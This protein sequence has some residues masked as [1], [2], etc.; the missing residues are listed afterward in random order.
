MLQST[1][2]PL[3]REEAALLGQTARITNSISIVVCFVMIVVFWAIRHFIPTISNRVILRLTFYVGI[4]DMGYAIFQIVQNNFISPSPLCTTSAWAIVFFNLLS[5]FLKVLV[6][7]HLQ[8]VF[9]NHITQ[10]RKYEWGYMLAAVAVATL[11]S[12]S[13]FV[14]G[15]Y[16]WEPSQWFCWFRFD[17]SPASLLWQ[18]LAYY[19]WLTL[20]VIYCLVIVLLVWRHIAKVESEIQNVIH[21]PG[22][23]D[24]DPPLTLSP[25]LNDLEAYRITGSP[26]LSH[27]TVLDHPL[28][29]PATFPTATDYRGPTDEPVTSLNPSFLG[30]GGGGRN[31]SEGNLAE[32]SETLA[33]L[34]LRRVIW[35]P[36]IPVITQTAIIANAFCNYSNHTINIPLYI[37]A[38]ALAGLQGFL[39]G[40]VFAFDP[41]V[42]RAYSRLITHLRERY[43]FQY[44]LLQCQDPKS[45]STLDL[46]CREEPWQSLSYASDGCPLVNVSTTSVIASAPSS[47]AVGGL[48]ED[49]VRGTVHADLLSTPADSGS[50]TQSEKVVGNPLKSAN[51]KCLNVEGHDGTSSSPPGFCS[52]KELGNPISQVGEK[53]DMWAV[54]SP[55]TLCSSYSL[56]TPSVVADDVLPRRVSK[57]QPSI[58]T[59]PPLLCY[60][61]ING[62][63]GS[64]LSLTPPPSLVDHPS[65]FGGR[66]ASSHSNPLLLHRLPLL[67]PT[68]QRDSAAVPN[69]VTDRTMSARDGRTG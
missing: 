16:G 63:M 15:M 1:L 54:S 41:S 3:T 46:P 19:M 17:G 22:A 36:M 11:C 12:V 69:R 45:L 56:H 6:A 13:P 53:T 20:S 55:H 39:T 47:A 60:S 52:S 50:G 31:Y 43:Y 24:L 59:F 27:Q 61:S 62:G 32:K 64:P 21:I 35:Y 29:Q 67:I 51:D 42:R 49:N 8:L 9:L 14:A 30:P 28:G 23:V 18:W 26:H 10:A 66:R 40:V 2:V 5:T 58:T 65:P 37:T 68:A 48:D 4:V 33:R 38:T 34:C 44:S 7:V 25:P 57:R